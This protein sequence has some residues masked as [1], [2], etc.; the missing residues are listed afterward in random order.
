MY[1]EW[2]EKHRIK[3]TSIKKINN[4]YYLYKVTSKRVKGKT[5][6]VSVQKYIGKITEDGLTEAEK[7]S[8]TAGVSRIVVLGTL[9]EDINSSDKAILDG[10]GAV[11]TEEGYC[12]GRLSEKE[13]M[14]IM[15]YFD[16]DNGWIRR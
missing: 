12:C 11:E 1:P 10:V 15:K 4:S 8:F 14:V 16:Y 2:V 9:V 3:G 6:P 13:I 7:I 5:Y